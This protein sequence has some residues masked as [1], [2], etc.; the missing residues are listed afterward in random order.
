V[1]G[2]GIHSWRKFHFW[3][4]VVVTLDYRLGIF[5]FLTMEAAISSDRLEGNYGF[6]DQVLAL[7]WVQDNIASFGGDPTKVTIV[8]QSAGAMSVLLH[9][10]SPGSKGLYH[11]AIM[12][13]DPLAIN[14][15]T[16]SQSQWVTDSL[17]SSTNCDSI[18]KG[19][20]VDCL[21]KLTPEELLEAKVVAR[22]LPDS[23]T[24]LLKWLPVIDG[25]IISDQPLQLLINGDFNSVPLIIG[26]NNGEAFTDAAAPFFSSISNSTY[27]AMVAYE[28]PSA[29]RD[30]I[31][32]AYPI[33]GTPAK[34]ATSL[35]YLLTDWMWSCATLFAAK[36]LSQK[37]NPTYMYFMQFQPDV[38]PINEK[39]TICSAGRKGGVACHCG[40]LV[41]V[42]DS[43]EASVGKP[44][45]K[46]SQAFSNIVQ[47]I[48]SGFI[49]T[50]S[51]SKTY[52]W[53]KFN[54]EKFNLLYLNN[55]PK[56]RDNYNGM[57]DTCT[58]L[59]FEVGYLR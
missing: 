59:F 41:Y 13:S 26:S 37:N 17:A 7:Q 14:Y 51:P 2:N 30:Q 32:E 15:R 28:F 38:Y 43:A 22:K 9:L 44:L 56:M 4:R 52:K 19:T 5:G 47:E 58:N 53:T 33:G 24:N 49:H 21:R 46:Y 36:Y 10:V 16:T 54:E 35:N 1:A 25:T 40:E 50:G 8:G 27:E 45:S 31:Y 39:D 20:E 34:T 57:V 12:E 55:P 29:Y 42:F 23:T 48:W 6:T 18:N 3:D 11:Q